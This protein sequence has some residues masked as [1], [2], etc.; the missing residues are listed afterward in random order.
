MNL[1]E[2]SV[3]LRI[4][5]MAFSEGYVSFL[6][7]DYGKDKI[8]DVRIRTDFAFI[9]YR[10]DETAYDYCQIRHYHLQNFLPINEKSKIY[11]L[12]EG[13][14]PQM[15]ISRQKFHLAVGLNSNDWKEFIQVVGNGIILACPIKN[16]DCI[17][18]QEYKPF[19]NFNPN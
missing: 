13:F 8:F 16:L 17:N 5:S 3:D 11:I 12:P 18:I 1:H 7:E 9:N 2:F 15:R 14:V 19:F 6:I 10:L 4:E